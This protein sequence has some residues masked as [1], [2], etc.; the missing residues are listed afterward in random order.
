MFDFD[1]ITESAQE[2]KELI[3]KNLPEAKLKFEELQNTAL[4]VAE[5][6]SADL[7]FCAFMNIAP[8]FFQT[9]PTGEKDESGN[10]LVKA[11]YMADKHAN[12]FMACRKNFA[13]AMI[14]LAQEEEAD[15]ETTGEDNEQNS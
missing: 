9:V 15:E 13:A 3:Q 10:V 5:T 4:D 8:F 11:K 1:K 12:A 7:Q 14:V 2:I 6:M